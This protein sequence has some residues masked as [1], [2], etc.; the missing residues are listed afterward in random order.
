MPE[1][2]VFFAKSPSS[3]TDPDAPIYKHDGVTDLHYEGEFG[4]AV[5]ETTRHVDEDDALDHVF[6]F[7]V[8]NDVTARDMQL[9]DLDVATIVAYISRHVTLTLGDVVLTGT[10]A[11]V[12]SMNPGDEVEV[13][14]EGVGVLRNEV[15]AP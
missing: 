8:G 3:I 10:P 15:R 11:G 6:G 2:P 1:E 14:V 12:G 7:L 13:D 4:F 5:G 9:R